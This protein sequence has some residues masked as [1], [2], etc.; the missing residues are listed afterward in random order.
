MEGAQHRTI[1]LPDDVNKYLKTK[2]EEYVIEIFEKKLDNKIDA[3]QGK[4]VLNLI[5]LLKS[6]VDKTSQRVHTQKPN[7]TIELL[8]KMGD[9]KIKSWIELSYK[10]KPLPAEPNFKPIE[11]S[12]KSK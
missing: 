7:I 10:N 4:L 2:V 12:I 1:K 6:N 9:E 8:K 11:T 3:I 5:D